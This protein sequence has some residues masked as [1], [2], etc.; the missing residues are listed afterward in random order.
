MDV[1]M[2]RLPRGTIELSPSG[3]L[4]GPDLN[5]LRTMLLD[6]APTAAPRVLLN[7][8][9]VD[10]MDTAAMALMMLARIEIEAHGGALV[11]ENARPSVRSTM[12]HAGLDRFVTIADRR[13]DSL[14]ELRDAAVA[15][16]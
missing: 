9:A 3:C 7:L 13:I 2:N 5:E 8:A 16:A 14:R 10:R 15:A 11:I 4:E 6:E 1:H 12:D